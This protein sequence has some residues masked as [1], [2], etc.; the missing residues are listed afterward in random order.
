MPYYL[1]R[2]FKISAILLAF[3][4]VQPHEAT[5]IDESVVARFVRTELVSI[6]R[7]RVGQKLPKKSKLP[8]M[9]EKS[10]FH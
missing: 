9:D 1:H 10:Y 2:R 6:G 5:S 3:R 8:K 7:V 4:K